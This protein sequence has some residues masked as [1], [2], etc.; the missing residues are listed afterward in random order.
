MAIILTCM[1]NVETPIIIPSHGHA[2]TF[3]ILSTPGSGE[4]LVNHASLK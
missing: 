2:Y 4:K 3:N 1:L